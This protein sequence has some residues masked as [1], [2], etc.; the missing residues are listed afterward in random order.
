[1]VSAV[2]VDLLFRFLVLDAA[3]LLGRVRIQVDHFFA[4]AT[5]KVQGQVWLAPDHPQTLPEL[6]AFLKEKSLKSRSVASEWDYLQPTDINW[7]DL[8]EA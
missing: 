5:Y 2:E 8:L 7:I 3:R 1:M 6:E 4:D